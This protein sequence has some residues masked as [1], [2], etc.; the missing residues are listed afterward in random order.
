MLL[1]KFNLANMCTPH[2]TPLRTIM[3]AIMH[4]VLARAHGIN[5]GNLVKNSP[6]RQIKIPTK[7]SG[8]TVS[9]TDSESDYAYSPPEFPIFRMQTQ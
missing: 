8:Y 7:V 5:F 1:A 9:D 6:N 2:A 4:S 3:R